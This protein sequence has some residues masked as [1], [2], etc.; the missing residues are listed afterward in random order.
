MDGSRRLG[1]LLR[2]IPEM[3]IIFVADPDERQFIFPVK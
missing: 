3:E 2:Q 1:R